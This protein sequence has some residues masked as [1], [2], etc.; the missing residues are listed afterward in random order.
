MTD[1]TAL[2][3]RYAA[4][5]HRFVFWLIGHAADAED[6]TAETFARAFAGADG[7]R[8]ETAKAY[9]LTIARNLCAER[10][11]RTR[12]LVPLDAQ[13]ADCAYGPEQTAEA[14]AQGRRMLA[15]LAQL[16]D[17][18]RA[19]LLLHS[20]EGLE[21]RVVAPMLGLSVSALKVRIHRARLRLSA[22]L[23]IPG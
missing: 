6:I 20:Y 9:L 12:P 11:R 4:D 19:A 13:L 2:Y 7:L 5:I 15:A 18:D 10:S 23:E 3:Q 21:Q 17:I 14:A 1:F 16:S 8:A 22:F